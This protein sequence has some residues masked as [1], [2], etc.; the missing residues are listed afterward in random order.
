M[1][2]RQ[3]LGG[4]VPS[5]PQ[6]RQYPQSSHRQQDPYDTPSAH[7]HPGAH[8]DSAFQRLRSQRR[9]PANVGRGIP[10]GAA[11]AATPHGYEAADAVSPVSPQRDNTDGRYWDHHGTSYPP[12]AQRPSPQ[13]TTTP[14]ADNFS[15]AAAGGMAG[16]AMTVADQNARESG[17]NAMHN[18]Q[19]YPQQPYQHQGQGQGYDDRGMLSPNDYYPGDRNSHSSLQGLSAAAVGSGYSTPGQRTPLTAGDNIYLD[20]PYQNLS[21]HQASNLGVVNPHDI[22]DDGDDGLEYGRKGPRTSMLSLGGSSHRGHGAAAAA[23]AVAGGVLGGLVGRNGSGNVRDQYAPVHNGVTSDVASARSGGAG[24]FN[25]VPA[26]AGGEKAWSAAAAPKSGSAKKWKIAII[27]A[28]AIVV[29]AAIVV[30]ILFG[31]VFKKDKNQSGNSG[32]TSTAAG[33]TQAHGDV[34]VDDP[35]IKGLMNNPNLHKVFL[36]MDYTPL[37][38]QYPECIHNPPSQNNVTRDLA[39][40]SQLTNVVRL[41][42]TDCNQTQMLIHAVEQLKLKD[43]IKIWLGVWQDGNATTNARQLS[44]MWDILDQYGDSY[45]KG[46]IVANEILFRE[47]MTI[48]ALGS[49]LEEVRSNL[50]ARGMKLPVAT[51]DLGDRWTA[52]LA[53]QSDAIMANIHPFFAGTPAKQAAEWTMQFWNNKMST[54]VK[55]DRAMNIIS[56]T[57]WPSQGGMGCG[58]EWETDCPQKAVAG[59]DEMNTFME[60]WVCAALQ[61]GTEY[62]WFE[63]FDE[64]WKLKFNVKGKEW[65]D[66]WGLLT[67][68]REL[69]KGLKIPDCGGKRV[70]AA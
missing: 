15:N 23:G 64:P 68:D 59:I 30:G 11:A 61:N 40:L 21:R 43:T 35:E 10:Y 7:Y 62:F 53:S 57:G 6:H 27:I 38:T 20:D 69:K 70:P 18:N 19:P 60:D 46:I 49:L 28:A 12:R 55:S 1:A 26:G 34:G 42:G 37:N 65:E 51:S 39:V 54:F 13:S 25:A 47:Q 9:D 58:N 48:T 17:L 16:I 5:P 32:D 66:H 14:G 24:S 31:V 3:P 67:V 29:I 2:E 44:Q 33:D 41:Y 50:T 8:P 45:F 4:S 52:G 36:G 22:V 56:E 63:A